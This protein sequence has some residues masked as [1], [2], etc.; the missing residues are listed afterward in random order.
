MRKIAIYFSMMMLLL[1]GLSL[2][3]AQEVNGAS[4]QASSAKPSQP[5]RSVRPYRLDFSLNELE[6][7][8]HVNSRHY[9]MNLT[10]GSGDEIKIGTR[11][12]VRTGSEPAAANLFQ[13]MDVGTKIWAQLREAGDDVQLEVRSEISNLDKVAGQESSP[14]LP[15]IV[16]QIQLRGS[17]L[18]VVG[19]PI[20]IGSV[21]DPNSNRQFQLEVT[22]TKLK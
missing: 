14:A 19:K 15:P 7:G 20:I 12:P 22:V 4:D 16:R 21:D 8:K 1:C 6:D 17:T 10:A 11:V 3:Q 9:S 13:Y 18:L 2:V 5:Q